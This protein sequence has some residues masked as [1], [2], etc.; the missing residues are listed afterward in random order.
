[1]DGYLSLIR[2]GHLENDEYRR[3]YLIYCTFGNIISFISLAISFERL[4]IDKNVPACHGTPYRFSWLHSH[5]IS[6]L[7]FWVNIRVE[8]QFIVAVAVGKREALQEINIFFLSILPQD[9]SA[10]CNFGRMLGTLIKQHACGC[11][12]EDL[13]NAVAYL[14]G[15]LWRVDSPRSRLCQKSILYPMGFSYR[16][17][18]FSWTLK[19]MSYP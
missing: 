15:L 13:R 3:Q 5:S 11:A 7:C 2:T 9:L 8:T 12:G 18:Y 1:M 10:H 17:Q 6:L 4:K 16:M 19:E 14:N